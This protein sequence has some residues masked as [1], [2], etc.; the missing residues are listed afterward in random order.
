VTELLSQAGFEGFC[1]V[2]LF[3]LVALC[4]I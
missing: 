2:Y 4:V 1:K 3:C